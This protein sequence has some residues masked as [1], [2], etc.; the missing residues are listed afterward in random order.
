MNAAAIQIL[1]EALKL[2]STA[3]QVKGVEYARNATLRRLEV[4]HACLYLM[5]VPPVELG[6]GEVHNLLVDLC[7]KRTSTETCNTTWIC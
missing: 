7:G 1:S 2:V 3:L 4:L 5:T 6:Q